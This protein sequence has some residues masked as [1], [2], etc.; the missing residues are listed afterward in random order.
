MDRLIQQHP[1]VPFD[2]S[3]DPS[4]AVVS[5]IADDFGGLHVLSRFGDQRWDLS[6]YFDQSNVPESMK[7]IVW[8]TD[9]PPALLIDT[10]ASLFAWF[11][12]GRQGYGT[13]TARTV[14]IAA[15]NAGPLLRWLANHDVTSFDQVKPL[16]LT[17]YRQVCKDQKLRPQGTKSRLEIVNLAWVFREH[18]QRPP[19]L[20]PWGETS[21]GMFCGVKGAENRVAG[22]PGVGQTPVIPREMQGGALSSL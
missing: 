7:T 18:L 11:K 5:A 1:A 17:T 19:T 2:V 12:Q 15:V 9:I 13:A 21:F 16:H 6:P 4:R 10:K 22:R 20:Y 14:F 3:D 8:P